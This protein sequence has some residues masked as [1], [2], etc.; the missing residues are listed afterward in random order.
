[1]LVTLEYDRDVYIDLDIVIF[2]IQINGGFFV[3]SAKNISNGVAVFDDVVK[4]R[5][6]VF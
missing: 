4:L 1:M 6:I 5:F 3:V 2:N